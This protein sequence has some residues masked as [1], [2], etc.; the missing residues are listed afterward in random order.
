MSSATQGC[1]GILAGMGFDE[2]GPYL[3]FNRDD[4]AVQTRYQVLGKTFSLRKSPTRFCVGRFDLAT[5]EKSCCP[6]GVELLQDAKEVMCP[7]CIE[8][9]GFNPSFYYSD[10]ISAQ[11][12]AYNATPHFV[13]LAYFAPNYVKAGIS[14]QTR[15]IKRL[16]EQGARAAC[17]VGRFGCA[18]EARELEAALCAQPDIVETMRA[19]VKKKLL[20]E[21]RYDFAQAQ[22]VLL[23]KIERLGLEGVEPLKDLSSYYF[24]GE[25]PDVH[26]LQIPQGFDDECGGVCVGMVGSTLI[27]EQNQ[28]MYAVSLKLWESHVVE[29]VENEVVCEYQFEP[30]QF[31]LF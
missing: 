29:L 31:S 22:E 30:Q 3:A 16:L 20:V 14:S 21:E 17:V 15:G 24:L 12:R 28:T 4:Q 6:L 7:A 2:S 19:S 8:A 10:F 26:D 1:K 23:A 13:Y 11:Q 5:H 9:T 25:A 27:F 18:E